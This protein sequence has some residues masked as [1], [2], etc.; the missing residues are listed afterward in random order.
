MRRSVVSRR[1]PHGQRR[2]AEGIR[3]GLS[4]WDHPR[5]MVVGGKVRRRIRH[6][7]ADL[8]RW[9]AALSVASEAADLGRAGY[10]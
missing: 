9:H 7:I 5:Q 3:A 4:W 10:L 2:D 6:W 8:R 1:K